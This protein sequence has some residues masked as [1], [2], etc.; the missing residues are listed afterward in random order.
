MGSRPHRT[1][2][3][4]AIK[5]E[6]KELGFSAGAVL[7]L[8]HRAFMLGTKPKQMDDLDEQNERIHGIVFSSKGSEVGICV[9][10]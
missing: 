5:C 9:I 1:E 10:T 8:N 3:Q 7:L 6:C 4:T 2:L